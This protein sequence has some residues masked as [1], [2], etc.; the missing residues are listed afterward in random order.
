[1]P[2]LRI[3]A[4]RLRKDEHVDVVVVIMHEGGGC[5]DNFLDHQD[6]LS[7]CQESGALEF[8]KALPPGLVDVVVAGHTHQGIAKRV[9]GISLIEPFSHGKYVGWVTVQL[10]GKNRRSEVSGLVPVC[11]RVVVA[12][13]GKTC[14]P[15]Q[16]K[17]AKGPVE[18]A[19]FFGEAVTADPAVDKL[20]APEMA[21]VKQ[22]K[23]TKLGFQALDTIAGA[24]HGESALGN[25][26]ADLSR[27]LVPHTDLGLTNGGGLRATL[28]PGPVA[29]GDIFKVMPFDNQLAIM[30][31][32]GAEL[33]K[34]V[35]VGAFGNNGSYSWSSN[36]K[37]SA[38]HCKLKQV[39]VNGKKVNP[40]RMYSI[41][42]SDFLAGGGSGV[43][44]VKIPKDHVEIFWDH[45]KL[46][47]EM[48]VKKLES[49]HRDLRSADYYSV[50]NPR[51]IM[52]GT[53]DQENKSQKVKN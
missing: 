20:L 44:S 49:W 32:S 2:A 17:Q 8:A 22:L 31:V 11:Q 39:T 25:L 37:F 46:L 53:C 19:V 14:D 12:Q 21:E 27:E 4:E 18:P 36:L 1:M 40:K 33:L 45:D 16:I 9:N 6:D 5:K 41:A 13:S 29:Y 48:I 3:E 35:E 38:D 51:Q 42:T 7:T 47:R 28:P 30:R 34:L 15:F 10:D 50:S 26:V 43:A 52:A 24:F 23:E